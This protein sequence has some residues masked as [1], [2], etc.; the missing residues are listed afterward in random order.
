MLKWFTQRKTSSVFAEFAVSEIE[1]LESTPSYGNTRESDYCETVCHQE[2]DE[3]KP[4]EVG[5]MLFA[6]ITSHHY[7]NT[8]DHDKPFL[9]NFP[10][11]QFKQF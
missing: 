7:G 11:K 2:M 4:S 8:S 3:H 1:I 10:G 6:V 9:V 5:L